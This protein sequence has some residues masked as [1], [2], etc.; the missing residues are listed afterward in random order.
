MN[1]NE[2]SMNDPPQR[3]KNITVFILLIE[4]HEGHELRAGHEVRVPHEVREGHEIRLFQLRF[5]Y[6]MTTPKRVV[7]HPRHIFVVPKRRKFL[8]TI[9]VRNKQRGPRLNPVTL[10]TL[11]N[12]TRFGPRPFPFGM[13][14]VRATKALAQLSKP[15]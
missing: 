13:N 14:A 8:P 5:R 11:K 12:K 1:F 2:L 3:T 10:K 6:N 9:P 7:L 4:L 15:S